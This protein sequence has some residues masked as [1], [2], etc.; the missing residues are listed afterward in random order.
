[1]NK[2]IFL[3]ILTA[4]V[5]C[6]WFYTRTSAASAQQS[7]FRRVYTN[8]PDKQN[9]VY[10]M[11]IQRDVECGTDYIVIRDKGG[12]PVAICPRIDAKGNPYVASAICSK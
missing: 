9:S 1:M 7:I 12:T 3:G 5:L 2:R 11:D 8:V 10:Y 6:F 4:L